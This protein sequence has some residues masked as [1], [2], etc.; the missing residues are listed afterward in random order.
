VVC[1]PGLQLGVALWVG[2]GGVFA[3]FAPAGAARGQ[4]LGFL[5]EGLG[6][7][8]QRCRG[9]TAATCCW[10]WVATSQAGASAPIS[11]ACWAKSLAMFWPLPSLRWPALS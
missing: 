11:L 6:V 4:G 7:R 2:A 10:P 5:L 1:D 3:F 9:A 8:F